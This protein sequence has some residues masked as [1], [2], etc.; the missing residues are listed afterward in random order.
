MTGILFTFLAATLVSQSLM[1]AMS[2]VI[3]VYMLMMIVKKQTRFE[4]L[5]SK[6]SWKKELTFISLWL[7]V[8][9]IGL[10]GN[11]HALKL[12]TEW[13]WIL[14]LYFMY[15]FLNLFFHR[16]SLLEGNFNQALSVNRV[17]F[18][19]PLC[20]SLLVCFIYGA[21]SFFT[22]TDLAT[23]TPLTHGD[24]FAG[25]LNDPMNFSHIYGMYTI[26]LSA[27]LF[28]CVSDW[29]QKKISRH[30]IL[31]IVTLTLTGLSIYLSLTRGAWIGLFLGAVTVFFVYNWRWGVSLVSIG[32]VSAGILYSSS[33]KFQSRVDQAIYPAQGYD[34][35]RYNLWRANFEMFKDHPIF[36]VGHGDYKRH[37]PFYFEKLGIP[38]DHF[39][40][41]AH[42]Q[43][44]Q[45][46]SNTGIL[47]FFFYLIFI[48]TMLFLSYQGY[49]KTKN[50]LFLGAL[51]AQ[52]VFHVGAFTECN[53]ERAKV[54]LVYLFFC[55][56]VLSLRHQ[57]KSTL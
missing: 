38:A 16:S 8:V 34:S 57:E 50:L 23:Q 24:R 48:V 7:T 46:L 14:N 35:E 26:F 11:P 22:H 10:I 21:I 39:Q 41:H 17:S 49:K 36:G 5:L 12:F 13:Q 3:G 37:L 52:I 31:L 19:A 4:P 44:I 33:D 32:I 54:R 40:S 30:Q 27:F 2:L 18:W 51:G 20:W 53:F 9:A 43:Y 1:D 55:A 47:G 6:T 15:W 45:A 56:L 29:T 25:A 42:N 28:Q